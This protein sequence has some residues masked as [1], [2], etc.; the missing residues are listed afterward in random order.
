MRPVTASRAAFAIVIALAAMSRADAPPDQ[1]ATFSAANTFITDQQTQLQWTRAP[2]AQKVA[3]SAALKICTDNF[4][5]LPT[6]RELLTIVDESPHDDWDP[7]AG[8]ATP[9]YI[10]PNA[11]PATPGDKFW[12]MSPVPGSTTLF[13]TVD[14]GTGEARVSSSQTDVAYARCVTDLQ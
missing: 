4:A 8:V 12:T 14:F 9:R 1:Y 10:D 2:S 13:M 6:Y 5:R 11:F 3:Q 7:D